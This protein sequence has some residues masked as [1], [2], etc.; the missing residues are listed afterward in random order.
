MLFA[1]DMAARSEIRAL[2]NVRT[3]PSSPVDTK[4]IDLICV[5]IGSVERSPVLAPLAGVVTFTGDKDGY[6][7]TMEVILV[8]GATMRLASSMALNGLWATRLCPVTSSRGSAV[9]AVARGP[10]RI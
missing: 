9:L 3:P 1:R 6:G 8:N 4:K 7:N 2:I 10:T 5:R